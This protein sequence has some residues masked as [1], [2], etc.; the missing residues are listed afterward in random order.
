MI[1]VGINVASQKHDFFMMSG[2]GEIYTKHSVSIPNTDVGYK[3]LHNAIQEFCGATNDSK[4]RIGLELLGFTT[5]I[6]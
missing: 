2:Q 3:K 6:S 1:Y 4:V 5:E